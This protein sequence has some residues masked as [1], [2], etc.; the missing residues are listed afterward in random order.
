MSFFDQGF[1]KV[2]KLAIVSF[3]KDLFCNKF[4]EGGRN[5]VVQDMA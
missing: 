3:E 2:E 4:L 1:S 5:C